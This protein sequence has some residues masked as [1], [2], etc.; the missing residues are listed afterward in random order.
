MLRSLLSLV[1]VGS[2]I[3][4]ATP[5][6]AKKKPAIALPAPAPVIP[7]VHSGDA[8]LDAYYF[9]G[10]KGRALWLTNDDHRL[11]AARLVEILKRAPIDG[12]AEGPSLAASV[13]SAIAG[14]SL[15]DD[16]RISLAWLKYLRVLAA[17]VP[18]VEYGDPALEP[19]KPNPKL[20][21]EAL[22]AAP[23][24][25]AEVTR[26]AAVNPFYSTLREAALANGAA[27]DPHVQATLA[28]LR[29]VPGK[30]KVILVDTANQR[31]MM[32]EDGNVVDT[33][34]VVV[35]KVKSPTPLIAGSIHYVTLNPYWNIPLD[36]VKRRIAPLVIKRGTSYLKAA[37][38]VTTNRWGVGAELVD[39]ATIDWKAVAAGEATA[40]LRQMP[41]PN[42]MMGKMKFGFPNA[43]DI[44]LHDTPHRE[45]FKKSARNLS[46]GCVR[47]EQAPKLGEWLLGSPPVP[48][49]DNDPEQQVALAAGVPVYTLYLTANVDDG[50][51]V[52]ADDIYGFDKP[53]AA[54]AATGAAATGTAATGTAVTDNGN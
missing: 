9:Y 36:V 28:R 1:V 45:L 29:L 53:G 41:G 26:V 4:A 5:V 24:M 38:Y 44:F 54:L 10:R 31:L 7:Q 18:G 22:A 46:M 34:K 33:M 27:E 11:A 17:P 52:F 49:N 15:E 39:P 40:Y 21:L 50:K 20:A 35:G 48:G 8:T 16:A 14:G 37:R 30:G 3:I 23:S 43:E 47:L 51:I 32:V 12:L 19:K 42:N 6:E 25:A 13:Q 2:A